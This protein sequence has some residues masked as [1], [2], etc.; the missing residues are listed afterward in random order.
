MRSV[1]VEWFE[2]KISYEKVDEEGLSRKVTE[3][4][5]VDAVNYTEAEERITAE[6]MQRISTEFNV[7]GI[8]IAPYSE[9]IFSDNE[10]D[11]H[12]FKAKV[13]FYSVN[14]RNGRKK[15]LTT[16]YLVQAYDIEGAVFRMNKSLNGTVVDYAICS[17]ADAGLTDVFEYTKKEN[18]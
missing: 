2:T 7:K 10:I 17:V 6:M 15:I 12:W 14:E 5:V 3:K 13:K 8:S 1:I 9:I 16:C 11:E 18:E 4:Y